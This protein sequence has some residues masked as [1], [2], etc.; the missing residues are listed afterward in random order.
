[1]G[2]I[3]ARKL[4]VPER[5]PLACVMD[6]DATFY[7][8]EVPHCLRRLDE[9]LHYPEDLDGEVHDDGRIWSHALWDIRESLG[10]VKADTVIFKGQIDFPGT[11][12][13]GLATRTVAAAKSLYGNAV[14]RKVSEAF[15]ARGI[16]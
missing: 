16:L 14:A 2:D 10:N 1:V 6:W 9:N 15:E 13:T 3:M 7:T 5:A 12:M 4:G 8:S 11:T